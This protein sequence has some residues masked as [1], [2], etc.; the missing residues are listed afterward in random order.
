MTKSE[1]GVAAQATPAAAVAAA[2]APEMFARDAMIAWYRGE[3]AAA[4][5]IIDA[6]CGHIAQISG[7]GGSEYEAAFAAIHRRRMNW[8]PV[9]QMQRFFSIADVAAELK[10]VAA[11]K[12]EASMNVR[13]MIDHEA[14][15]E[16]SAASSSARAAS[17]EGDE[18]GTEVSSGGD[19]DQKVHP[20][21]IDG[22]AG[23]NFSF[24]SFFFFYFRISF[25]FS[26][27]FFLGQI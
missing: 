2:A 27:F 18:E 13:E 1:A 3:F 4:N 14:V 26:F 22:V 6:L 23:E 7:G 17:M 9:I 25:S 10:R 21:E 5:A 20:E 19:T 8:I 15:S 16:R 12:A 24:F 11:A